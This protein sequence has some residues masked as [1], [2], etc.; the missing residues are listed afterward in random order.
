MTLQEAE[1]RLSE[2][3]GK[4]GELLKERENALKE[5]NVAFN[6]ENQEGVT[7]IAERD[8]CAYKLYLVNGESRMLACYFSE[9]EI[10]KCDINSFYKCIDNSM[11]MLN[12]ANGRDTQSPDYQKRLV[13]A[14]AIQIREKL[15]SETIL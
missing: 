11:G 5:W 9:S 15:E 12:M 8:L 2:L 3:D 4:I 10:T 14:K 6:A 1:T 7:C 13:Y